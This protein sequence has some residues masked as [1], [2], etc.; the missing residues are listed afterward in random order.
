[1]PVPVREHRPNSRKIK[2]SLLSSWH[3]K[4]KIHTIVNPQRADFFWGT[5]E[6]QG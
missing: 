4:N 1:M 6:S 3:C 5:K 2:M